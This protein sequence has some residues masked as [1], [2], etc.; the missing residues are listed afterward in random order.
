MEKRLTLSLDGRTYLRYD[1]LWVDESYLRVPAAIAARLDGLA[2]SDEPVKNKVLEQDRDD[3]AS[4]GL[5]TP[6][7]RPPRPRRREIPLQFE[8]LS[9][10]TLIL[11]GA[12]AD[13]WRVGQRTGCYQG[14]CR[15]DWRGAA[16]WARV[17]VF[18]V[19]SRHDLRDAPALDGEF[20]Q[21]PDVCW[22]LRRGLF[23]GAFKLH[24][25]DEWNLALMP[26]LIRPKALQ[27]Y[28]ETTFNC[29]EMRIRA[30]LTM[31]LDFGQPKRDLV[32]WEKFGTISGGLPSLGK[33][34]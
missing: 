34:R 18:P 23:A 17:R 33:R 5:F 13:G 29:S 10:D 4:H 7:G 27:L 9:D 19:P 31:V 26:K 30:Q 2:K 3:I 32:W 11:H 12:L 25:D 24:Q 15:F 1:G 6:R 14:Q 22:V 28:N 20:D 8:C 21:G 16:A